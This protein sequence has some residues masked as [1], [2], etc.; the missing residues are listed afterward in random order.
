[1][2][3]VCQRKFV[4]DKLSLRS[5]RSAEKTFKSTK[6]KKRRTTELPTELKEGECL[7]ERA[8]PRE[9]L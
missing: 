3:S 9:I 1:M 7:K 4:L 6:K 2:M 5:L 8:Q